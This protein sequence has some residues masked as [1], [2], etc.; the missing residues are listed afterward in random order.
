MSESKCEPSGGHAVYCLRNKV[1]KPSAEHLACP[2]CFGRTR[3]A[4]EV[5]DHSLFCDF[6][7]T[8][9]PLAFGFPESSTRN[10]KG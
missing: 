2:Y 8:R 3:D 1:L 7:E 5:G 4:V 6:D 10:L 9:D